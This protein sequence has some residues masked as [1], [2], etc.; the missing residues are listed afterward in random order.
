MKTLKMNDKWRQAIKITTGLTLIYFQ[1]NRN[2]QFLLISI[3]S[4]ILESFT[5]GVGLFLSILF[6]NMETFHKEITLFCIIFL[7]I[8]DSVSNLVGNSLGKIEQFKIFIF[9]RNGKSF[10]GSMISFTFLYTFSFF[11]LFF[12]SNF[13]NGFLLFFISI[14]ISVFG[15]FS[16]IF[17]P[18][19]DNIFIPVASGIFIQFIFNLF[20]IHFTNPTYNSYLNKSCSSS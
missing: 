11:Y 19:D 4:L 15:S 17:S 14:C 16:E 5:F 8:G 13:E 20:Q 2:I 18:I 9:Q 1:E 7:T 12:N 6:S 3:S 10:V